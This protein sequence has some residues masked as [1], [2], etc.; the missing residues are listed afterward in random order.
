[1]WLP[2]SIVSLMMAGCF[3]TVSDVVAF[4]YCEPYEGWVLLDSQ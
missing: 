4:Q 1:M 2:I 3:C